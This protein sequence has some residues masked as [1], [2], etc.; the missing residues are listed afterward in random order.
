MPSIEVIYLT[1][2]DTIDAVREMLYSAPAGTQV[3][4]VSPWRFALTR[5]L[6]HLKLIKRFG[7]ASALDL[8]LVTSHLGT[9]ALAREAGLAV[10][11]TVPPELRQYRRARREDTTGLPARVVSVQDDLHRF[12]RR[13][14]RLGLGAALVSLLVVGGLVASMG[15]VLALFMPSATVVLEPE[16]SPVRGSWEVTANT[17]YTSPD[18]TE[19]VIPSRSVQ[20]IV[21]GRAETPASGRID[22]PDGHASGQVVLVNRTSDSVRVP[23]GTIVRTGSGTNARFYTVA[24]VELSSALFSSARVGVIALDPGL[25]GNVQALTV[26]VVEG[27]AARLVDVINDSSIQGGTVRMAPV[28]AYEDFDRLRAML[29]GQLQQQAYQ[30][31]VEQL[32]HGEFVPPETVDVQVM[33]QQYDQV[34][35]QQ[36]DMVSMSMKVAVRGIAVDGNALAD[37]LGHLLEQ[38]AEEGVELIDDSL[39]VDAPQQMRV[40]RNTIHMTASA[41]GQ[42]ARVIDVRQV[43]SGLR[44]RTQEQAQEWL[45]ERLSLRREPTISMEP[46]WWPRM[47][48][49]SGRLNVTISAGMN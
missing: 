7:E 24:D 18:L 15:G 9:R 11:R 38:S 45:G 44:G 33:L 25:G 2:G 3:W 29:I 22:V 10:Y 34:V 32:N 36:S 47:P 48:W 8:R 37:L 27:E 1:R 42:V 43:K 30:Q 46:D 16:A 35:D 28:V 4:L 19:R 39:Q 20:V 26:N 12:A 31:F 5:S 17:K 21:E 13:P 41:S 49:L 14:S 40:D 6:V 23:K